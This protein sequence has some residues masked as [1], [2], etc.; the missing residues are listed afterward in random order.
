MRA[1]PSNVFMGHNQSA[2]P[3]RIYQYSVE[4]SVP[5]SMLRFCKRLPII[6]KRHEKRPRYGDKRPRKTDHEK[7]CHHS[8]KHDRRIIAAKMIER[9][10][11]EQQLNHA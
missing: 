5:V 4:D 8:S 6:R 1:E 2:K 7:A 9:P 11:S 10:H 3:A